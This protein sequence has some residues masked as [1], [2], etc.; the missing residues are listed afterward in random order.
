MKDNRSEL[1]QQ[2]IKVFERANHIKSAESIDLD[3]GRIE[4]RLCKTTDS[5]LFLDGKEGWSKLRSIVKITSERH[6]KKTKR[7]SVEERYYITSLQAVPE[8][9]NTYIR[10]YWEIENKSAMESGRYI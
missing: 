7:C 1:K 4:K 2:L 8:L 9:L 5:L 3:H 10:S 6:C